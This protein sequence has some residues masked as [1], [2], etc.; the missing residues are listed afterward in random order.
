MP[1]YFSVE[2]FLKINFV[3]CVQQVSWQLFGMNGRGVVP[4]INTTLIWVSEWCSIG[5]IGII[6]KPE[7]KKTVHLPENAEYFIAALLQRSTWSAKNH[8]R[9]LNVS[10]KSLNDSSIELHIFILKI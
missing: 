1:G 10:K 9:T 3:T 8:V 5:S 4:S 7:P 2:T 6:T